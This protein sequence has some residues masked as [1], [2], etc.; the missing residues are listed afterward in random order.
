MAV[1]TP[2]GTGTSPS[3]FTVLFPPTITSF[4][5]ASGPVGTVVTLTGTGF[6]GTTAVRFNGTAAASFAVVSATSATATVAAG[7]SSGVLTLSTPAGTATSPSPFTVLAPPTIT[8]LSPASGPV[9]TVVTV[10]GTDL[11]GATRLTL[12]GAAV[13]GFAGGS[14]TSLTFT[15]PAGATSGPV[16]AT[17]AGGGSNATRSFTV[18][19]VSATAEANAT[20]FSVWPNPVGAKGLLHVSLPVPAAS[21]RLSLRNGLGQ[22]VRTR[23]FSGSGAELSTAGLASGVYL[24]NVQADGHTS[25]VRRV[26]VE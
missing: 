10:T 2:A 6:T 4:T 22:L 11:T 15:V 21:A 9:G 26:V 25:T 14:A 20:A 18:T 17:T 8:A 24:L 12:N 23:T 1:S 3:P 7:T 5:P 19:V 16:V 13:T